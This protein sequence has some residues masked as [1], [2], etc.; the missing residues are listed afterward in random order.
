MQDK[1]TDAVHLLQWMDDELYGK[2]V[3]WMEHSAE[4][5]LRLQFVG[6]YELL[7]VMCV[8]EPEIRKALIQLVDH[9]RAEQGLSVSRSTTEQKSIDDTEKRR[10]YNE[11]MKKYRTR[12]RLATRLETLRQGRSLT[13]DELKSVEEIYRRMW[14]SETEK[15]VEQEAIR[16]KG[17]VP[18]DIADAIR[19]EY[20]DKSLQQLDEEY[21]KARKA[22][23]P[24][25][26]RIVVS[27]PKDTAIRDAILKAK[28][29]ARVS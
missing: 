24:R 21:R 14:N 1:V 26:T 12:L 8:F 22:V 17:P 6:E 11:Y 15:L 28:E 23:T 19:R 10:A 4:S 20:M 2:V 16:L 27:A 5:G 7:N 13:D 18:K 3:A 25:T 29:K 9:R